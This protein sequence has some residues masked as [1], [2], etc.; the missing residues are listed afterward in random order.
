MRV[1][2]LNEG[3]CFVVPAGVLLFTG[4]DM[5]VE[6]E[7]VLDEYIHMV[8]MN[9]RSDEITRSIPWVHLPSLFREHRVAGCFLKLRQIASSNDQDLVR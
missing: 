5:R 4:I 8:Y 3:Q 6:L 1:I 9:C 2:F 7:L